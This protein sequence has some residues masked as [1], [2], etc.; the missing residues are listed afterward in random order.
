[1]SDESAQLLECNICMA[2]I[3]S[4]RLA[5]DL[6]HLNCASCLEKWS[7]KTDEDIAKCPTCRGILVFDIH[8]KVGRPV[9]FLTQLAETQSCNCPRGCGKVVRVKL[10]RAHVVDDCPN[11]LISCP[12]AD[13]GCKGDHCHNK[14]DTCSNGKVMRKNMSKHLLDRKAY[15]Q[16]L[17]VEA[18]VS[19]SM[20]IETG[21][22]KAASASDEIKACIA[23]LS[24]SEERHTECLV[25]QSIVSTTAI[26]SS[27]KQLARMMEARD[28][29]W[30]AELETV[31]RQNVLLVEAMRAQNEFL[32]CALP[33]AKSTGKNAAASRGLEEGTRSLQKELEQYVSPNKAGAENAPLAPGAPMWK[34]RA[35]SK[36]SQIGNP[37]Q[38]GRARR[39]LDEL[40]EHIQVVGQVDESDDESD[41]ERSDMGRRQTT[42]PEEYGP[43]TFSP[44]SPSYS[45]TSP[46]YS[47]TSPSYSPTSPSYSPTSPA[48]SPRLASPH[49][50]TA[51]PY[52]PEDLTGNED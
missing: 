41:E 7:H 17:L 35:V 52:V 34:S 23:K 18:T 9:P 1:M 45:P 12:F 8:G 20:N 3:E 43:T 15:H 10:L 27:I 21:F 37:I 49:A 44:T 47:P 29:K 33:R 24:K 39:R 22:T 48:Y 36:R 19:T 28:A 25:H 42:M 32:A 14:D 4:P 2:P 40:I 5:C 30:Q 51:P 50:S 31:K 6:G 38:K 11:G 13:L 16:Q 46:S 26:T